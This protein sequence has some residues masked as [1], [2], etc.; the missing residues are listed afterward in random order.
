M[1]VT[2]LLGAMVCEHP[3]YLS[4]V[5]S[6]HGHIP[7]AFWCVEVVQPRIFVALGIHKGDSYCAFCQAVHTLGLSTACYG[8]DTGKGDEHGE[9]YGEEVDETLQHYHDKCYGTFS[10]LVRSTF[11]E[12]VGSFA[13]GSIDLLHLDGLHTS[14]AMPHD[15]ETW[16]PKLSDHAV[17]LLHDIN[18]RE[19]DCGTGRL[20]EELC[21]QYPH[22]AFLH[23]QGLGVLAVGPQ[24]RPVIQ[25]LCNLSYEEIEQVRAIFARL[26]HTV[27]VTFERDALARQAAHLESILAERDQTLDHLQTTLQ[28]H[29]ATLA[30]MNDDLTLQRFSLTDKDQLIAT[31]EAER[32]TFG[33]QVGRW[34]SRQRH[35]WAPPTS[36]HGRALGR[37]M[38]GTRI[39]RGQGMM[40][41]VRRAIH[42]GAHRVNPYRWPAEDWLQTSGLFDAAYY[43]STYPDVLALG[44]DPAEHYRRFGWK[45][46][47]N[48]HGLF[49][50]AFYLR[51]NP[52]V[53]RARVNPLLHYISVGWKQGRD[54]H[55]LFD[56][57]F[58]LAQNLDVAQRGLNPLWHYVNFG[59]HE[60][61]AS[62]P[63]SDLSFGDAQTTHVEPL[64]HRSS[65]AP[66]PLAGEGRDGGAEAGRAPRALPDLTPTP[67]LPH[68]RGR[69]WARTDA[70]NDYVTDVLVNKLDLFM[71]EIVPRE[72][73]MI[74]V[75]IPTKNAGEEFRRLL[76]RL[77]SQQGFREVEIIVVDSGSTDKTLELAE[78][79]GAKII[80]IL[81]EE[82]S[83][84]YA[85]NLGADAASGAYLLFTVQDALPPS[86][87]WLYEL[88]SVI[89]NHGVSAVS[90][91]EFPR[92]N[93]DLFYR[94]IAWNHYRFLEVDREDKIR[95][96]VASKD[97][98]TLRKSGQLSDLACLISKSTFARY[99]Y[100]TD[101]A[102]DLD[103]GLRLIKDG[104]KIAFLGSTRII[105]SHNRT[106][107]YHLKR[108]YVDQIFL[109]RVLPGY[110]VVGHNFDELISDVAFT[111]QVIQY[112][113]AEEAWEFQFSHTISQF[114]AWFI[115]QFQVICKTTNPRLTPSVDSRL[116]DT[117]FEGFLSRIME[118]HS[119]KR[120]DTNPPNVSAEVLNFSKMILAYME[121]TYELVDRPIAE[122]F[123][124]SLYK[125]FAYQCGTQLAQCFLRHGGQHSQK[126]AQIHSEL[127]KGV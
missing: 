33:A 120:N 46:G 31:Y 122:D 102:E 84:S 42:A 21:K 86:D 117:E 124:S 96:H 79:F 66:S 92:E 16:L 5:V 109:V 73:V 15:F 35:T 104:Y 44:I 28:E 59:W 98:V 37:L 113:L 107:Y 34:L 7:F 26:G 6:W 40:P 63:Q 95:S 45:E 81:P 1:K 29:E 25:R 115:K 123:R 72:D 57:A 13:D 53:A 8:I 105:H 19:R 24:P 48:P 108:G 18:G 50:T 97:Y 116:L 3:E 88:F 58:Y 91:A 10:R 61:R 76:G 87:A 12:A 51:Q 110:S 43:L 32:R 100:K 71:E 38:Q 27:A 39:L 75:V 22:F 2:E 36:L 82:F 65:I 54:P 30:E 11:D 56:T 23:G 126:L 60:G 114:S 49:D 9:V 93:A 83:H 62:R 118:G 78:Q 67:A 119:P 41:L 64:E 103:L 125:T 101:Y 14:T 111:Y 68:R 20:W 74:S 90:C 89:K 4:D 17:V 112:I 99:Q 52:D 121:D 80:Q 94:A 77:A 70:P 55:P 85:R 47:R 127:S 69:E 106:A